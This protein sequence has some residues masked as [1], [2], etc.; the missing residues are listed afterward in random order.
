M[1]SQHLIALS[2]A[3]NNPEGDINLS[4]TDWL[5]QIGFALCIPMISESGNLQGL[6]TTNPRSIKDRFTWEEVELLMAITSQ[7][8]KILDR[9]RLQKKIMFE[10]EERKKVEELNLL[11][12]YFV[13]SVSHELRTPLTSIRMFAETLQ[14]GTIQSEKTKREYYTIIN[15]ESERLSRLIDNVLDFSRIERGVKEYHFV[16]T[17]IKQVVRKAVLTMKY[18]FEKYKVKCLVRIPKHIPKF[19]ADM[20]AL[21]EVIINLLSNAMKYSGSKKEVKLDVRQKHNELF[22][23]V[24]DKGIGIPPQDCDKIFE[25]F[26]RSQ[27]A[28]QVKGMGLGLTLVKHVVE[29]HGGRIEVRSRVGKGST[30]TIRLP[31]TQKSTG[32]GNETSTH[33]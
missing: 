1:G 16:I 32:G 13:S 2:S 12:S 9:L 27:G 8:S 3:I 7:A 10:Q 11:K 24:Q 17:D 19:L 30:F 6:I 5:E 21:E 22:I 31:L 28:Y 33:H 23:S 14:H 20:D 25:R 26:Y 18:Q 4:E 29:A 15:R